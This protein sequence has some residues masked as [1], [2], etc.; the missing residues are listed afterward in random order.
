MATFHCKLNKGKNGYCLQ[1]VNY[2]LREG[3]YRAERSGR[4]DLVYKES[5]NM[6]EWAKSPQ[7]FWKAAGRLERANGV[8]Y[9]EFEVALP[10]ELSDEENKKIVR[11]YVKQAIGNKPYTFAIHNKDAALEP[12][13]KQ[14]H[15]HIMFSERMAQPGVHYM[16]EQ[17]FKRYNSKNPEL[18]GAKKDTRFTV[19]GKEIMFKI[20]KDLENIIND[21]YAK[22]GMEIRISCETL[23]Q[24]YY[25]ALAQNNRELARLYDREPEKHLGPEIVKQI[26]EGTKNL[27]TAEAKENFL[28]TFDNKKALDYFYA[29]EY[30]E[31]AREL[32]RLEKERAEIDK[33]IKETEEAISKFNNIFTEPDIKIAAADASVLLNK[34]I[35]KLTVEQQLVNKNIMSIRKMILSETRMLAVAESVYTNGESKKIA[36]EYQNIK[37]V[38]GKYLDAYSAWKKSKPAGWNPVKRF[39]YF[40]KQGELEKWKDQIEKRKADNDVKMAAMKIKLSKPEAQAEINKLMDTL[41]HKNDLRSER[42]RNFDEYNNKLNNQIA[43]CYSIRGKIKKYIYDKNKTVDISERIH[44]NL[45]SGNVT[46]AQNVINEL[47]SAV[48]KLE[49]NRAQ[50]SHNSHFLSR[51]YDEEKG[52]GDY[53]R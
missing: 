22:K 19:Y 6:P 38:E 48:N 7:E 33:K 50:S 16:K 4:E 29:R 37:R 49:T 21:A 25:D 9:F 23:K 42:C 35:K 18:G 43:I 27:K 26:K 12:G 45:K 11:E 40:E 28:K 5:G 17:F 13:V 52:R 1:H 10:N 32:T 46:Q 47:R 15:A 20:R 2:I 14:P 51:S 3:Q 34:F 24:R 30:K 44:K 53:E 36:R 41:R 39:Q 8:T 31:A